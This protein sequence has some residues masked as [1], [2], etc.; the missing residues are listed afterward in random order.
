MTAINV[1]LVG[2]G[3]FLGA[4][5]RYSISK[6]LNSSS[7]SS[8]PL[9][10]LI[11]NLAGSFLLGLITGLNANM[12]IM[13]L[14]GTGFIGA[15]TTFSALKFEMTKMYVNNSRKILFLYTALTYGL[16]IIFAYSGYFVGNLSLWHSLKAMQNFNFIIFA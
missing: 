9:G 14:F 2:I 10:T 4:I 16:G 11:V 12:M 15:F 13:L 3:G 1:L 6:H 8:L 5:A 7:T